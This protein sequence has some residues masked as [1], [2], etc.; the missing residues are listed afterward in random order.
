P[1]EPKAVVLNGAP[2]AAA[3]DL[4]HELAA[5]AFTPDRLAVVKGGPIVRRTYF[6][7]LLARLTPSL[8]ELPSEY[9]RVL[10]QRNAGLRRIRAGLSAPD[11]VAPWTAQLSRLGS[12]LDAARAAAVAE[13]APGFAAHGETLGLAFA[14]LRY[15]ERGLTPEELDARLQRDL[16]RGTTGA[17]PH[18]RDVD[19]LAGT[20]DLRSFGSQGEQRAAVL[21]LVLAEAALLADRRGE[22]PLLLLDDVLS[23]LDH[24]RREALLAALPTGGQTV[25]T[26]TSA[27]ALPASAPAPTLV[28]A[29]TP[30]EAKAA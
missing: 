20:R 26:A 6:D 8:A 3:E 12:E 14:T 27:D 30:G 5:L 18:L 4:R 22:P 29:V 24:A 1:G 17:G 23:E 11:A 21:A 15:E 9:G 13:L 28:I 7:R 16:E 25:V 10:G 19:L 2:V